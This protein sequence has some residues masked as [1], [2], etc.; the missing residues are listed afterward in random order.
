M[1]CP[2]CNSSVDNRNVFCGECGAKLELAPRQAGTPAG[3]ACQRG[4]L[5]PA[6]ILMFLVVC[7][8]GAWIYFKMQVTQQDDNIAMSQ[9]VDNASSP[10][11]ALLA[12]DTQSAIPDQSASPD[13]ARDYLSVGSTEDSPVLSD[14][15]LPEKMKVVP[16]RQ[17]ETASATDNSLEDPPSKTS[18]AQSHVES[19]KTSSP[20]VAGVQD[21]LVDEIH[22]VDSVLG[23]TIQ[24]AKQRMEAQ[25]IQVRVEIG[26]SAPKLEKTFTVYEYLRRGDEVVLRIYD[27]PDGSV[28]TPTVQAVGNPV[29][30][31]AKEAQQLAKERGFELQFVVGEPAPSPELDNHLL[32][33]EDVRLRRAQR[34][35]VIELKLY[36]RYVE[37]LGILGAKVDVAKARLEAEGYEVK[38]TL[39]KAAPSREKEYVVEKYSLFEP[40]SG[41]EPKGTKRE[42]EL[43]IYDVVKE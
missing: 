12:T 33:G 22:D 31:D 15:P 13:G 7:G 29:R 41:D 3:K 39:N 38:V 18:G 36:N 6:A 30:M 9:S 32:P 23:E 34:G 43:H 1:E 5:I 42:I 16:D 37:R 24:T 27:E 10:E 40:R 17:K 8:T 2:H 28:S 11:S 35:E 14:G 26:E 21:P 25:G 20:E 19:S 4:M